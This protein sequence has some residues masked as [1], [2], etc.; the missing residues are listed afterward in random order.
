MKKSTPLRSRS[1]EEKPGKKEE[2]RITRMHQM[3]QME[4]AA[5]GTMP[6]FTL[7]TTSFESA[8]EQTPLPEN[9]PPATG[10][11]SSLVAGDFLSS[12]T[13]TSSAA[14]RSPSATTPHSTG[15]YFS[16]RE[17][18]EGVD[19]TI[20][21][22]DASSKRYSVTESRR[23][24]RT[25]FVDIFIGG[26]GTTSG[27]FS[28]GRKST[29]KTSWKSNMAGKLLIGCFFLGFMAFLASSVQFLVTDDSASVEDK[30]HIRTAVPT[31][32]DQDAVDVIRGSEAAA[33]GP[34]TFAHVDFD[35]KVED[36][37]RFDDLK[38]ALVGLKGAS[39]GD[40][41]DRATSAFHALR[42]LTDDDPLEVEPKDPALK[43]R[44]ALASLFF[45][46]HQSSSTTTQRKTLDSTAD[47]EDLSRW[48]RENGWMSEASVCEWFAVDC[49][50][51]PDT[52][53][54]VVV[55]LNMTSN[56]LR[57]SIP[58]D[59]QLLDNLILLDLSNNELTGT[60]PPQLGNLAQ[61]KYFL[62]ERNQLS[63]EIPQQLRRM[64]AAYEI[65]L[66]Y[67][68]LTGHVPTPLADLENLRVLDLGHNQLTGSTENIG[69]FTDISKC[70]SSFD[71][72]LSSSSSA[73]KYLTASIQCVLYK[74][75]TTYI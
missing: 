54:K 24:T 12:A 59:L 63:G 30:K 73:C 55:H 43:A 28:K 23:P 65:Y 44:F 37:K 35:T 15:S 71:W 31:A 1:R 42:W 64:K 48:N 17:K 9:P 57:G 58:M 22:M 10:T 19:Q 66:S 33:S 13:G 70:D 36:T 47:E 56:K 14:P 60:I 32:Y 50:L 53:E 16:Q 75:Q 51:D 21:L 5:R 4:A 7:D 29:I 3:E 67:N 69:G 40:F 45:A 8:E 72:W 34:A 62:L 39:E 52:K 41:E 61:V 46:T 20:N 26:S 27:S 18:Y 38:A 68:I 25:S 6:T 74:T 11:F 2:K 49:E